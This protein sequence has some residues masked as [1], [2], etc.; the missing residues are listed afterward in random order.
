M[1]MLFY[2]DLGSTKPLSDMPILFDNYVNMV[3]S[4]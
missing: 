1:K 4:L 3:D 2:S